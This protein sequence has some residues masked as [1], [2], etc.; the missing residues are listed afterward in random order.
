MCD[1]MNG[2]PNFTDIFCGIMGIAI[3]FNGGNKAK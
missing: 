2:E 1:K 3:M